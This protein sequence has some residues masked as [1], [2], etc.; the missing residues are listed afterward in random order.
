MKTKLAILLFA[1]AACGDDSSKTACGDGTTLRDGQCVAATVIC[2]SGTTDV[3]GACV[4]DVTCGPDTVPMNNVCVPVM[5]ATNYVQVEQLGRPGVNEA[6]LIS[7]A[8]LEGY[9]ATAPTFAG[10]PATVL[11]QVVAE[12]KTVLRAIYLGA[13]F[14]N[15]VAGLDATTGVHPAGMT[16]NA[17]GAALLEGDGETQT[18]ATITASNAYA[19]AVFGLFIPDVMRIDTATPSAYQTLCA[20][21]PMLLCGGRWLRDDVIDVTYD[22]F[23]NGAATCASPTDC[24]TPNQFNALVSDGVSY[25]T[26]DTG[27]GGST[28]RASGDPSNRQQGHP[29]LLAVFPYSAP[30]L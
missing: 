8:F 27:G 4:P 18:A 3:G 16:C 6:L 9:N 19:D 10:V 17:V 28:S 29:D 20:S 2:G 25:Q 23:I 1:V 15:G 13:C 21:G 14:L 30:P 12:A 11:P 26:A 7:D 5:P 24:E 22:F